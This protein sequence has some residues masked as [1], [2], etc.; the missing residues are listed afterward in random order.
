MKRLFLFSLAVLTVFLATA[1]IPFTGEH[2][3]M[4]DVI[5]YYNTNIKPFRNTTNDPDHKKT[6]L[7][8]VKFSERLENKDYQFDRWKWYWQQ[9]LDADGYL[10]SPAKTFNSWM[11]YQANMAA[12][13]TTT[14]SGANW[15]FQGDDS[16]GAGGSGVGRINVIAF[17]PTVANTYWIGSAGGGAWKTTNNG[18]TWT[19]MTSTL[20]LLSVTDIKY[21]PKNPNTM[22]MCTGDRDGSD[23]SSIGLL[24]TVNGGTTWTTTG[25]I[26]T[27][28]Q[29]HFANAILVNPT[30]TNSLIYASDQGIYRSYNGGTTWTSAVATGNFLQLLYHP[31]D[32]NIVYATTRSKIYR[33]ANG[34][35]T[36]TVVA[37]L[38]GADRITLAV[39]PAN[40][41][42]VKA[43]VSESSDDG[44]MGIWNSTDTGHTF[45][46]IFTPAACGGGSD[47]L[48]SFNADGT[49][50]GGQGFYDLPIAI[51][52]ANANNVFCGGVN[53][54]R[55]TDGGVSWQI[56]NQWDSTLTGVVAI[57]ADKH[58]MA[59][60]PLVPGRFF[61]TNDGGIY[62]SDNPTATGIWNNVTNGMGITEFYRV[63]VT[64]VATYEI[65]GA[66]DV[67]TKFV[68]GSIQVDADGGDGMECQMDPVDNTIFYASS[69][70]GSI[71]Q[72]S[73]T[74]GWLSNISG[75]IPGTPS[76]GWVTPF[77]IEPTCHTC[78]VAG[79]Q[80]VYRSTDE[81]T[82]W[83][84]ISGALTSPTGDLLRVVTTKADSNTFYAADDGSNTLFYTHN[85]GATS[86]NTLT[87]P[88]AGQN[89]SD[90]IIDPR[91]SKQI[92]VAFSGYTSTGS[93]Q[94][95]SY[96]ETAASW[97][98]YNTGLPDVPVE[99]IQMD[100]QNRTM[101]AG[102]DVGV[103]YRDSTMSSWQLFNT[104]MPT[105]GVYDLQID[106]GTG[107]IWAATFGRSLWSSARH[108]P[109]RTGVTNVQATAQDIAV[110]PNPSRGNFTVILNNPLPG[111]NLELKIIDNNGKVVW[112]ESN[113]S[114]NASIL[115]NTSKLSAGDY[116][117]EVTGDSGLIGMEKIVVY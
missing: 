65:A 73:T 46:Q 22:Y 6:G 21:N 45:T 80:D 39:T 82:T 77:I 5:E 96:N 94:I 78:I 61:E 30:D 74:A 90:V 83:T 66:Q 84:D 85:M 64:S 110:K 75:N 52:P 19:N 13:K 95:I 100:Y 87:A 99:C 79:Y 56:M 2:V 54:W 51:D 15:T 106:Y 89:I 8:G 97:S 35:N 101:Y 29:F 105:V 104:G 4:S 117:L 69:E 10:V 48:L 55:S 3:K 67:G 50:C 112:T 16:S 93:P 116:I 42:I 26:Y 62:W 40:R 17:H 71:D 53:G 38:S 37:S 102:T 57:H 108:V 113:N 20:A 43:I 111:Q 109:G 107:K 25:I 23:Y 49:G 59:I 1:Q 115:V 98:A 24:K 60:H 36:W 9:H 44:L 27:E 18:A 68:Q 7:A 63:A 70:Y 41:A 58:F 103:F 34:G 47:N 11:A 28:D 86:W 88:Y 32:T 14:T 81:G 33:S 92:Y 12:A 31:T 91:N 72:L 114:K 76:G